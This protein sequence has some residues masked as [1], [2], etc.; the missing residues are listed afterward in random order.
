MKQRSK[1]RNF[2]SVLLV[3]GNKRVMFNIMH[4]FYK[5]VGCVAKCKMLIFRHLYVDNHKTT[6][7]HSR[8]SP[9]F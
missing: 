8:N 9:L 4:L 6:K 7:K 5:Q 2:N 1:P 3:L